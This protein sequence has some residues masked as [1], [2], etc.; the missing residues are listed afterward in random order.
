MGG[1]SVP[2]YCS[3]RVPVLYERCLEVNAG[4]LEMLSD[5]P[6]A[7]Q[8]AILTADTVIHCTYQRS[9]FSSRQTRIYS[10]ISQIFGGL[11]RV[12]VSRLLNPHKLAIF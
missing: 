7:M 3:G 8:P 4:D 2:L 5:S 10:A 9:F 6:K 12:S 1:M 11:L